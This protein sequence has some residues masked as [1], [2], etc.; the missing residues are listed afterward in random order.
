[1]QISGQQGHLLTH[2]HGP[3]VQ[4]RAKKRYSQ[5][6]QNDKEMLSLVFTKSPFLHSLTRFL[7]KENVCDAF[8]IL[9]RSRER[10]RDEK[11]KNEKFSIQLCEN[12]PTKLLPLPLARV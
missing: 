6:G 2:Q 7:P 11:K 8:H 12:W 4:F 10:R 5:I 9:D 1:M 3:A